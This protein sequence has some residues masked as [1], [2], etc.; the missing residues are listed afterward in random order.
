MWHGATHIAG[1]YPD[2]SGAQD[3]LTYGA[4]LIADLGFNTIKLELSSTFASIKYPNQSFGSPA[5]LTALAQETAFASVFADAR[6]SRYVLTCFSLVDTVENPWTVSWTDANGDAQETEI[7]NLA[8]HLATTYPTKTFI[9]QNWEGDWQLLGSFTPQAA[10]RPAWKNSYIDWH[11]RRQRAVHNAMRDVS[12]G[13]RVYYAIECNRVLDDYGLRVHR[14]VVPVIK[15]DMV[16]L[17]CYEAI[18]GW[19]EAGGAITDQAAIEADIETKLTRIQQRLWA[20]GMNRAT[21]IFLG[22]FGFPQ[23]APYWPV[24]LD[25]VGMLDAVI[26]TATALDFVGEIYWQGIS[27]EEYAAGFPRGFNLWSRNGSSATVGARN[28][29]GDYYAALLGG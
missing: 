23:E 14:D 10:Q 8:V 29:I 21:P 24:T 9:I 16:S 6:L 28:A 18:E 11:R 25:A 1:L 5:T 27:N 26:T 20:A 7:Y 13:G 17:S 2:R 12:T 4:G 19:T 15:P 22:E 3:F